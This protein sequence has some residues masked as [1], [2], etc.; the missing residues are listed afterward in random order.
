MIA[1]IS[2]SG[3]FI[4][5]DG[6]LQRMKRQFPQVTFMD[7]KRDE[8]ELGGLENAEIL[9]GFPSDGMLQTMRA[10]KW[11]Q[12]PSAGADSYAKRP[13]LPEHVVVTSSSGVFSVPGAEHALA[14]MLAL[15]RQLHVHFRQQSE[16][17]WK[18]NPRCL[19]IQDSNVTIIGMGDIGTEL[20]RKAKGLGACVIGVKRSLSERPSFVDEL[21]VTAD[22]D[23]AL[24]KSDFIVSTLP[25]TAETEG[26]ISAERIGRM[27][28]GAVFI[29]IGRG[30]TVD[31]EA[32]IEALQ[33]GHLHG[34]GLDV[35]AV[36][37]PQASS[38][39]WDMP[40]VILTAHAAG[41]SP[42]KAERRTELFAANIQRYLQGEPLLNVIERGRG[43]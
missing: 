25:L 35:T 34:A 41:V 7:K 8:W 6:Q 17:I 11:L 15:T 32:L 14:L 43:Y 39:L 16:R 9:I 2:Y 5:D 13:A 24:A 18:H 37:P 12:L 27:K 33:S 40:N 22:L 28:R 19:E 20:A 10:L 1:A 4:P 23:S 38:L 42:K 31:E 26:I 36:E 21:V 30:R 3:D 29:N